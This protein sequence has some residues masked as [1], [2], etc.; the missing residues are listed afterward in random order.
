MRKVLSFVL[1]LSLVLGSFGMAFAAPLS[2]VAGED[3]EDAVNVLTELGVVNGYPDGTFRPDNIVTRAEMAVIVVSALGLADYA[4]GTSNFSDMAGHWSNP[5]VAYATSLGVISGYPDGTF[6]PDKT[7]SYDEAATMLVAALGYNADSLVGTWP[8]NFVTKAKTLGILDGIKAG[9]AGANRGDIAIMTYQTL[10][11]TIGKT[12]KDGAWNPTVLKVDNTTSPATY[13]YDNMLERLG[14]SEK[15]G[16]AFVLTDTDAEE[17]VANVREYIG[18]YVTAYVNDDD[19]I[20]AIKEVKSTFLTG[21][22]DALTAGSVVGN[23]FE[24][25]KD[26]DVLGADYLYNTGSSTTPQIS[27]TN[28]VKDGTF[29][30]PA[31]DTEYKI[32]ANVSGVKIKDI[33][34]VSVWT[35]TDSFLFEDDMLDDD[36]INGNNFTLDDNDEID[37]SSFALLGV[38]SLEEIDEDNVVYVYSAGSPLEI[39]R[40]EVGTEVVTGEVTKINASGSKVT[41]GG[42]TYELS[43]ES[44]D[45]AEWNGLELEDEVEFYLDYAGKVYAVEAIESEGDNYAMVLE[46]ENDSSGLSGSDASVKLFLADGTTKIFKMD[47]DFKD[48]DASIF[49]EGT[50]INGG[51]FLGGATPTKA[52][53]TILVEYG[54]NEEGVVDYI[55]EVAPLVGPTAATTE[56][57]S[58]GYYNGKIVASDAIL[59]TYDGTNDALHASDDDYYG[60]TTVAKASGK[61]FAAEY[62][63]ES[64]KITVMVTAGLGSGSDEVY[65]LAVSRGKTTDSSTDYM[66]TMLVDGKKVD[67]PIVKTEYEKFPGTYNYLTLYEI[68]TNAKDEITAL[69]DITVDANADTA[70]LGG[71]G[72]TTNVKATGFSGSVVTLLP[73]GD[74]TID[75]DAVA[76]MFNADDSVYVA[77]SVSK[78]NLVGRYVKLIDL[79]GD[80]V[81]DVVMITKT[82]A[83]AEGAANQA[84]VNAVAAGIDDQSFTGAAGTVKLPAVPAGYTIV[85]K[86]S[87]T[88]GVYDADG[89]ILTDGTSNVVYTVTHTDSAKT[90]DTVSVVVNVDVD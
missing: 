32:A 66:V 13:T 76:Y 34:S 9:A 10:D 20:I 72:L 23:V 83:T 43:D 31:A 15:A 39:T 68:S 60:V 75:S 48:A 58:K 4:T 77:S 46:V 90:A 29:A 37:L 78:S 82:D 28:G 69:K 1:V 22:F 85:V 18:A 24:A 89:K 55:D 33:Y 19:E 27:F 54:L 57:T 2:D 74:V 12:D 45:V 3:F 21:E 7:V 30:A 5:Y 61:E 71:T 81:A 84:A 70:F 80:S 86:T 17:A 73:G 59:F 44:A 47:G 49:N 64:N 56:L 26:Y 41:V 16:G 38:S 14:A 51:R 53:T 65:G 50:W 79:D 63:I 8:A 42:K 35:V 67:Y 87:D 25:D 62:F 11:Q 88:L 40:I 36:N 6:K 52:T